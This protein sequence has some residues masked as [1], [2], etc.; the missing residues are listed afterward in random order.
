MKRI[1]D[2]DMKYENPIIT[3]SRFDAESIVTESIVTGLSEKVQ[4]PANIKQIQF[5]K[6]LDTVGFTF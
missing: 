2:Y 5:Q 1:S 6:M 3:I 4:D